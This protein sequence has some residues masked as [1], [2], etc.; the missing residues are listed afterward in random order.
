M[1]T[2]NPARQVTEAVYDN[3]VLRPTTPLTL[4]DH[5]RV[6][7][8]VETLEPQSTNAR[9]AAMQRLRAGIASMGFTSS[10]PFPARDNLHDRKGRP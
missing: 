10:A 2:P 7:L 3:G 4:R 5:Q 8:T 6:R 1:V 9:A